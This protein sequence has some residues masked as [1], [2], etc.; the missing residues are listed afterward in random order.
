MLGSRPIAKITAPEFLAMLKAVEARGNN[1]TAHR[2]RSESGQVFR[3]AIATGRAERDITA[4]LR[5]ALAP[6]RVTHHPAIIEPEKIG[7]LLRAIAITT[8]GIR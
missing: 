1:E 5:G 3:Y 4:D 6:V 8:G 2:L 7:E